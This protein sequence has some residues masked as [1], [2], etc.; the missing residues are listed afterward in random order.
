M[1]VGIII[2]VLQCGTTYAAVQVCSSW[3]VAGVEVV[4]L[5]IPHVACGVNKAVRL[6]CGDG[7]GTP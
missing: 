1:L 6:V 5:Y 7:H 4:W 2:G 3:A